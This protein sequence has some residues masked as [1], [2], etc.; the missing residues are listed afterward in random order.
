MY[1]LK[2][3]CIFQSEN[4][5]KNIQSLKAETEYFKMEKEQIYRQTTSQIKSLIDGVDN[6]V[7]ALANVA[8]A[9][10]E[11]FSYYFWVGFYIVKGE[12]LELG[13]FQGPVAC[14]T[15]KKGKGVCGTAWELR[16][17]IVVPDV[18]KFPGHI[19]CSSKSR[20]EIV[21]P[22]FKGSDVVAVI[23]VDSANLNAFDD[24]DKE[25]L[26]KIAEIIRN[27]PSTR[28]WCACQC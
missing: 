13:P 21:V 10:K 17:T 3:F 5:T 18:E 20:S 1:Y 22:V 8:A 25:G 28:Q 26:E 19:A 6:K 9:L 12:V 24:K 4:R 23:D 7:G 14:Y 2:Y 15:I 27:L 16:K 11:T